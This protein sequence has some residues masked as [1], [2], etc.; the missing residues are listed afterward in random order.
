M[1][2]SLWFHGILQ[3]KILEW[4][5]FLFSWGIFPT[6][7]S[8][9]GLP[10]YRQILY[11]LSYQKIC[12]QCRKPWFDSWVGKIPWRR[13]RLPTIQY[14]CS[15]LVA[16]L[17]KSLSAMWETWVWSLD[18]EDPLEEGMAT[19]P[20]FWPGEFHGLY[21]PWGHKGSDTTEWLSLLL[22]C[23]IILVNCLFTDSLSMWKY[24]IQYILLKDKF[25]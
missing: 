25:P 21:N 23:L 5:A 20:I 2:D 15:S 11:R 16:Q 6:Q 14:S 8:N 19:T 4:V 12:L 24:E 13:D 3:A 10:H 18:W 17:V 22:F 1:S 7:G 9:P